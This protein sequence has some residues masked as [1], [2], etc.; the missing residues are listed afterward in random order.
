MFLNQSIKWM[1]GNVLLTFNFYFFP[2]SSRNFN[3]KIKVSSLGIRKPLVNGASTNKYLRLATTSSDYSSPLDRNQQVSTKVSSK[4]SSKSKKTQK[5][6]AIRVGKNGF[7]GI[8]NT[9]NECSP[10]V[11]G[12]NG[13]KFKSFDSIAEAEAFLNDS[14]DIKIHTN[15]VSSNKERVV[16]V[17]NDHGEDDVDVVYVDGAC[18]SNG[19]NNAVSGYGVWFGDGDERNVSEFVANEAQTNN[20]AELRAMIHALDIFLKEAESEQNKKNLKRVVIYSDS[21]LVVQ[22]ANEWRHS[23]KK[24][25]WRRNTGELLNADLWM[26]LD[27]RL[28]QLRAIRAVEIKWIKAHCGIYGNEMADQL[29]VMAAQRNANT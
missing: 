24:L 4:T 25:G 5:F 8:V 22:G 20:R 23:W 13:S 17:D 19:R 2:M 27:T 29:A 9:W 7:H 26:L 3:S 15:D 16:S 11:T 14:E 12:V 28:I 10:L 21:N 1:C 6:Y 18:T